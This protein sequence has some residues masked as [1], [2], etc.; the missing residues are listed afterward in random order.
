MGRALTTRIA[1]RLALALSVAAIWMSALAPHARADE[2]LILSWTG[3]D[4]CP[5]Q[6]AVRAALQRLLGGDAATGAGVEVDARVTPTAD[7]RFTLTLVVRT[8]AGEATRT[9]EG[10]SCDALMQAGALVIALGI[11]PEGVAAR[12]HEALIEAPAAAPAPPTASP[13]A[14]DEDPAP[15][16]HETASLL[17][18]PERSETPRD[19]ALS[20]RGRALVHALGEALAVPG[21]SAGL[22]AGAGLRVGGLD[23]TLEG[24]WVAPRRVTVALPRGAG[25]R[26]TL[27]AARLRGCAALTRGVVEL[28]PCLGFELGTVT[29]KSRGVSA[30]A[31]GTALWAAPLAGL[32]LRIFF[33]DLLALSARLD[34]AVPLGRPAFVVEGLGTVAELGLVSLRAELG[35]SLYFP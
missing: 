11:D 4:A 17:T 28:A 29:G 9:L 16:S 2:A 21:V 31:T 20:L 13:P 30:P 23:L 15:P 18:A 25:A 22:V 5:A 26:F 27:L 19:E 35:A 33:S 12:T 14:P 7:A 34:A 8:A 1:A 10:A 6:P 3:P 24:L 32:E